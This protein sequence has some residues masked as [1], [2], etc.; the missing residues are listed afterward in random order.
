MS[1]KSSS[2]AVFAVL[3]C[4]LYVSW[5]L[6]LWEQEERVIENDA[7]IYYGY[8]PAWLIFDDLA[9]GKSTYEYD[10]GKHWFWAVDTDKGRKVFKYNCGVA[11]MQ[12]PF[13]LIAHQVALWYDYPITGFSEPY[14]IF[15]IIGS[16]FYFF[17]GLWILRSILLVCG[18]GEAVT[19]VCILL[20]GLST[21]LMFYTTSNAGMSHTYSFA[22]I[23]LFLF[24]TLKWVEQKKKAHLAFI[25]LLFGLITLIRPS[26]GVVLVFFVTYAFLSLREMRSLKSWMLPMLMLLAG[27][28]VAWA[29]QI[30]YWWKAAG[31]FLVYSYGRESFFWLDPKIKQILIGFRK[32][33]LVYTPVMVFALAGFLLMRGSLSRL[34]M[35][36]VV[37]FVINLYVI[38]CWWCWWYGG[39]FGHRAFV[40]TYALWA[41]P[42]AAAVRYVAGSNL[43]VRLSGILVAVFL[44]WLNVFQ[45]R[46]FEHF[47]LHHDAMTYKAWIRQFGRMEPVPD[48]EKLL[49][50]PEYDAA[51]EGDR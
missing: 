28:M 1:I 39:G 15:L 18:F 45:S 11:L 2:I 5:D 4:V 40:D 37:F 43:V 13:F 6:K 49:V 19:A 10:E 9:L 50:Y 17:T 31:E 41:I 12:A 51:L 3:L 32:G 20:V 47:G 8:L 48:Q 27:T 26:N 46:Q 36:L 35:A 21:N 16:T 22:L 44:I 38:S 24:L 7:R 30:Y 23:A 42:L 25:A 34:R 29:P 33:W 14:K